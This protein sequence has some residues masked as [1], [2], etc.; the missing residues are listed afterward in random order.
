MQEVVDGGGLELAARCRGRVQAERLPL[1]GTGKPFH[2]GPLSLGVVV[3]VSS[4]VFGF[5][6]KERELPQVVRFRPVR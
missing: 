2:L 6:L 4:Y 1:T 5:E 3:D